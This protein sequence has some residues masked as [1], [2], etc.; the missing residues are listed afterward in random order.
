MMSYAVKTHPKYLAFIVLRDLHVLNTYNLFVGKHPLVLCW[1]LFS[2]LP[3]FVFVPEL[4]L[5]LAA[6]T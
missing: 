3:G 1:E 6:I 5:G 4:L 2:R